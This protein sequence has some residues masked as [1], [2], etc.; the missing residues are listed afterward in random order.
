MKLAIVYIVLTKDG[1]DIRVKKIEV[2][3]KS[4]CFD[5]VTKS[6]FK[7]RYRKDQLGKIETN[8]KNIIDK[9]R[10][11]L[12]YHTIVELDGIEQ[13][14]IDLRA[15]IIKKYTELKEGLESLKKGL[16]NGE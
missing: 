10:V 13:A 11:T 4:K 3:E 16:G 2:V 5:R 14:K 7:N 12:A 6:K 9:S 8:L 1:L 15:T